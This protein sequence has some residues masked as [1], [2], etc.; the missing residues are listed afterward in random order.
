MPVVFLSDEE[1]SAYGR[2]TGPPSR[3]ELEKLFFLDDADRALIG[4]RQGEA[5]RLGFALQVTTAR[6]V[7]R[8]LPDPLDA[9]VEVV[10]YLAGQLGIADAS[11]V[12][13]YTERQQTAFDHQEEI[14]KAYG[15]RNFAE[16]ESDFVA[17]AD[18][19]AWNT[20]DGAKSIFPEGVAWMRTEK[21]LLPGVTTLARL[22]ARVREQA[23]DRLHQSLYAVLTRRQ[24]A[25]LELLLEVPE[26]ASDLGL[27]AVAQG[28]VGALGQE[29]GEG[30][31]A[32]GGNLG[33][34]AG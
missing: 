24:R 14:R 4:K 16:A 21:V 13:A 10:D 9:P 32:G 7:G 34:G 11:V 15:L 22:V 29:L 25:V 33:R 8:F 1:V 17:W 5:N 19:R 31:A 30:A 26:G 6:F 12:K 23:I 18:A 28:P 3:A 20:G 2:Y 27:G